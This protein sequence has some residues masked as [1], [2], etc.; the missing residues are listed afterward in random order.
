[1]ASKTVFKMQFKR[2]DSSTYSINVSNPKAGISTADVQN[3][4]NALDDCNG[5]A[6]LVKAYYEITSDTTVWPVA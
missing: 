2:Q 1:M 5:D 4:T 3:F 6:D